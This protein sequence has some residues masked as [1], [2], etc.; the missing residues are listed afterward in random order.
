MQWTSISLFAVGLL[1]TPILGVAWGQS[2]PSSEIAPNGKLRVAVIGIRVLG[3]VGQPIGKFIADKLGASFE[4]VVYPNP[5]AY[6]QSFGKAEWVSPLGRVFSHLRT[7]P[8]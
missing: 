7:K 2:A 8:M 4:P 5:Q 6:E 3:G 1:A